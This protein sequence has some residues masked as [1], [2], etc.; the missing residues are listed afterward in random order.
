MLELDR[1]AGVE[2]NHPVL[3]TFRAQLLMVKGDLDV[4]SG[5]FEK[6]LLE[7]PQIEAIR[8]LYAQCL[9]ARGEHAAARAQLTDRVKELARLDHDVPYWL[10]SAYAAAGEADEAF[11]WLRKAIALGNEN[12]P[13]FRSNPA[14]Q[15]L[16]TDER[17]ETLMQEIESRHEKRMSDE[18]VNYS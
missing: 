12:L 2:P 6:I 7:H 4:A 18:T 3:N 1:G 16:R 10:A 9:S 17:F 8:P 11:K 14:W 13:W 15:S 5:L